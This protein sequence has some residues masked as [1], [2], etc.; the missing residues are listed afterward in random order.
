[1]S[2]YLASKNL[3]QFPFLAKAELLIWSLGFGESFVDV[4]LGGVRV[5]VLLA[6]TMH[7]WCLVFLWRCYTEAV[8]MDLGRAA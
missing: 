8:C 3:L 2:A 5:S 1:M 6:V 4:I 7:R